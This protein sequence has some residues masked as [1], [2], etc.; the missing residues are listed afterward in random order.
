[1][2]AE[3]SEAVAP[4]LSFSLVWSTLEIARTFAAAAIGGE[5]PCEKFGAAKPH[6]RK[7]PRSPE[8]NRLELHFEFGKRKF[9]R[10]QD[11]KF[12]W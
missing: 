11:R 10:I 1:M 12:G 3:R 2:A 8:T 5:N 9:L 7:P 6:R 4:G